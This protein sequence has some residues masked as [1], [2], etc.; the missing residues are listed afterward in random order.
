M[1]VDAGVTAG[2]VD[3]WLLLGVAG[4]SQVVVRVLWST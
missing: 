3:D 2:G 4:R 1:G